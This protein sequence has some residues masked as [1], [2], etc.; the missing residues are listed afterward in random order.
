MKKVTSLVFFLFIIV[1][2]VLSGCNLPFKIVPNTPAT[3][4]PTAL[5]PTEPPVAATEPMTAVTTA[6]PAETEP[7]AAV[8]SAPQAT[9][10][11]AQITHTSVPTDSYYVAAQ[12]AVDCNTGARLAA[13]STQVVVSGCDY[14]N[15]EFLERPADGPD[16]NYIPALDILWSQTGKSTPWIFLRIKVT[17]LVDEPAG[18]QAG[19]ELDDNL[20]SRGDFLL[21][22]SEPKSTQWS[23]DGVQVWQ[24]SNGDVGGS[25]PFAFDQTRATAMIP[26]SSTAASVRT[27]TWPGYVFRPKTRPSSNSPSRP[28]SC[29]TPTSLAGGPGPALA[30]STRPVSKW[31]TAA[32][33][34]RPGTW[35]TPVRGSL[36]RPPKRASSPTC[37]PFW[38]LPPPRPPP[39]F[40]EAARYRPAPSYPSGIAAPA[41]ASASSSSFPLPP[42]SSLNNLRQLLTISSRLPFLGN[43]ELLLYT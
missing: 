16:G 39:P 7:P 22:A 35:I 6:A 12:V 41:R 3:S 25:K 10:A 11:P 15:R 36:E 37:V 40:R 19:F 20:D 31:S 2:F 24:D 26:S 43:L 28:P 13:G 30:S 38:N 5:P 14:W 32:R 27:R 9:T 21:L 18:Y 4:V 1:P 34:T 8:T 42:K 33:M 29:P 17:S 23:T